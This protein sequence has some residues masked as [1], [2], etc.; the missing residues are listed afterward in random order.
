MWQL[1]QAHDGQIGNHMGGFRRCHLIVSD[2]AQKGW[3]PGGE[4]EA[5]ARNLR[6]QEGQ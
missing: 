1:G 6:T 4:A 2:D 3:S 5:P